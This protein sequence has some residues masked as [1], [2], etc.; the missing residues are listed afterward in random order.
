MSPLEN[1]TKTYKLH[2]HPWKTCGTHAICGGTNRK[3]VE[4][5]CFAWKTME[6]LTHIFHYKNSPGPWPKGVWDPKLRCWYFDTYSHGYKGLA[7]GH[8]ASNFVGPISVKHPLKFIK[9][10]DFTQVLYAFSLG[11]D[12]SFCTCVMACGHFRCTGV[13][14]ERFL[15]FSNSCVFYISWMVLFQN[16]KNHGFTCKICNRMLQQCFQKTVYFSCFMIIAQDWPKYSRRGPKTVQSGPKIAPIQPNI[17]PK[18]SQV[19][20][21]SSHYTPKVAPTAKVTQPTADNI[22]HSSHIPGP[23]ECAVAIE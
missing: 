7:G 15:H 20:P 17:A 4:N 9:I 19:A 10:I 3:H 5:T 11:T 16:H 2:G 22:Q 8:L 23:A 6:H 12:Q 14:R 13:R 1:I 18:V 21:E